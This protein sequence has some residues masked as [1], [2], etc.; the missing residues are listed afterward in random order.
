MAEGSDLTVTVSLDQAADRQVQIPVQVKTSGV[1]HVTLTSSPVTIASGQ[2]SGTLTFNAGQD[3]NTT[4][5]DVVLQFGTLPTKVTAGTPSETTVTVTDAA[6]SYTVEYGASAYSVVEGSSVS[7]T[8]RLNGIADRSITVPLAADP[9]THVTLPASVT[10]A[11]NERE[12]T[13]TVATSEDDDTTDDTVTLSFGTL[14]TKVTA[15]TQSTASL[16]IEDD[17]ADLTASFGSATY[18]VAEGSDLT[19]T[20]SLDQAADRQ[21]QIP[22]QVKTSGVDHVT[23]TSSPVTIAS[24]Q[25][26]GT[27]T[28]NA[29]QDGNTTSDDV[30]LQFGTLPTKVTAGTPSETTVTVTDAAASYTVEYGAS[31][32]SVVEGS[33]V[34][35]TVR[36]N[37]IADR[38]IT[39]PLAADPS[40]YVTLPASVA[41]AANE[42]EKTITVATSAD[43]DTT[44]DTVTLSFGTLPSKVT[45]GPQTT[46]T[47]T[48][49]EVSTGSAGAGP[50]A[51]RVLFGTPVL[52]VSPGGTVLIEVRL[53]RSHVRDLVVPIQASPSDDS[54]TLSD[55]SVTFRRGSTTAYLEFTARAH[56]S[57]QDKTVTLSFGRLPSG[58]RTA[59]PRSVAVT[60][61]GSAPEV[62]FGAATYHVTEGAAVVV[63]VILSVPADRQAVVPII[64]TP[65]TGDFTVSTASVMIPS[66]ST[67]ASI[68]VTAGHDA[69]LEGEEVMLELGPL[70]DWL[71]AGSIRKTTIAISDDDTA[72]ATVSF[73]AWHYQAVEG[74]S[75]AEIAVRLD[76]PADRELVIPI[77]STPQTG[78]F[79]LSAAAVTFAAGS[80]NAILTLR[81]L[82]DGNSQYEAVTLRFGSLP[83]DV[84]A[85]SPSSSAITIVDPDLWVSFASAEYRV[86][87]G[88]SVAVSVML[89]RPA[90][91]LTVVPIVATPATGDF[92]LAAT[93]VTIAKG[94]SDGTVTLTAS[95]DADYDDETVVL[96]LG[97]LPAWLNAH[98]IRSTTVRI[99]E[100][101]RTVKPL[102]I[103]FAAADYAAEEGGRAAKVEIQL[104]E[105]ADRR[106]TIPLRVTEWAGATRADYYGVPSH[107]EIGQGEQAATL[108]VVAVD[109]AESDPGESVQLEF[110][111]LP[112]GVS[113]GDTAST[114]VKL[115]DRRSA[116]QIFTTLTGLM[117]V[118]ARATAEDAQNAIESRFE[119][120]RQ[121]ARL[122][123]HARPPAGGNARAKAP[124]TARGTDGAANGALE[125]RG[126][127][128]R[129][130][131]S[132]AANGVSGTVQ[133][134]GAM[135]G[136]GAVN[137][138]PETQFTG[139]VSNPYV[140]PD[141]TDRSSAGGSQVPRLSSAAFEL[142]LSGE[143]DSPAAD[144]GVTL[145]GQGDLSSFSGN[146]GSSR[147]AYNGSGRAG[148]VGVDFHPAGS[149]L[150]GVSF[151][152]TQ[153]AL[154]YRSGHTAGSFTHTLNSVHP[155]LY[156]QPS[157]RVS[158]WGIGGYG[159]GLGDLVEPG[160][161]LALKT[162]FQMGA[163]GSRVVISKRGNT[164]FGV[165]ADAFAARLQSDN[166]A[167]L[168]NFRAQGAATRARVVTE[169]VHDRHLSGASSLS[170]K[171]E[172]GGRLD[173]GD[174]ERGRGVEVGGR[175][176]FLNT[177]SGLD[178]AVVARSLV[179][180][181]SEYRNWGV[182]VQASW[183]PGRKRRGLRIGLGQTRGED[184]NGRT[185]LWDSSRLT[186]QVPGIE[187]HM[188]LSEHTEFESEVA[189]GWDVHGR[190]GLV[191]SFGRA[192]STYQGRSME[193]GA[194]YEKL[195]GL[196]I[197]M[198]L[199]MGVAALVADGPTSPARVGWRFRLAIPF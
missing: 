70:P 65:S 9:S 17:P 185:S 33:S 52:A 35:V 15:G 125:P 66:G 74:G 88:Q 60:I 99:S 103:G 18:T 50:P 182:G 106:I 53:S 139:H 160:W 25:S 130:I 172:A 44:D 196:G 79:S 12:K 159:E 20:V 147:L 84:R 14:P 68:T 115:M 32:Y 6:A 153:G 71:G 5:D 118:I 22:V 197:A 45:A 132:I 188:G 165:R 169:L 1:D 61:A 34:S 162:K 83:E 56:S 59:S 48:I 72:D 4:S 151:T 190:R 152:H 149:V 93:S 92:S 171:A 81:A 187:H 73:G 2:S 51:R 13:I 199:K 55:S 146:I 3:G 24:G 140:Q 105:A 193:F 114:T 136:S 164:E 62:S 189:Y 178:L 46:S 121:R 30:V 107:I 54:F 148:F 98:S 168:G 76:R 100:A 141:D 144:R 16:T 195:P 91:R 63:A 7:V 134:S 124:L 179:Y 129:S 69:D 194:E 57:A 77:V 94:A 10:F 39:V 120:K 42:R 173:A 31:A 110:G 109:D 87:E 191:T 198:P 96:E 108:N 85:G 27:L 26:S 111:A 176:G 75:A 104:A 28:F 186:S 166:S 64:V 157:K 163:A 113:A 142:P 161:Q 135:G 82:E 23:L 138:S 126:E 174:A 47:L 133:P 170:F 67:E 150:A 29:G 116:G 181:F 89:D 127:A 90:D 19:V 156:L 145:W 41:F 119:R 11:A 183:D 122:S 40:T 180:H 86:E 101:A 123:N 158:F 117:A 95:A 167:E 192:R 78:A 112:E 38:S 154:S 36:L 37:G 80:Q 97:E 137:S 58:L 184:G 43:D 155:Y 8:V 128:R 102:M 21:V 49:T 177:A 131:A 175:V 143:T